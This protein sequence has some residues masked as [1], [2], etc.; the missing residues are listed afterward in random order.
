[1]PTIDPIPAPA[2]RAKAIAILI[3]ILAAAGAAAAGKHLL[4]NG[5]LPT[6]IEVPLAEGALP[7]TTCAKVTLREPARVEVKDEKGVIVTNASALSVLVR[8]AGSGLIYATVC[9]REEDAGVPEGKEG[10]PAIA[11]AQDAKATALKAVLPPGAE[12]IAETDEFPYVPGS[13]VLTAYTYEAAPWPCACWAS[14]DPKAPCEVLVDPKADKWWAAT[15][16]DM[17]LKPGQWRGSCARQACASWTG[18]YGEIP[19][20]C[21]V[22][23]CNHRAC[24]E[25]KCG[26]ECGQCSADTVCLGQQCVVPEKPKEEPGGEVKKVTP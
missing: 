26:H 3:A 7:P 25:G 22:D 19:K 13:P 24:G 6:V 10:E 21:C 9:W 2:S 15:S 23:E 4:D 8:D 20:E 16:D 1:M 17:S 18:G 14:L 11:T 5:P 12:A